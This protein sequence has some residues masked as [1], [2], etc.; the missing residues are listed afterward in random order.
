[1]HALLPLRKGIY[2]APAFGGLIILQGLTW[3]PPGLRGLTGQ[4]K[5]RVQSCWNGGIQGHVMVKDALVLNSGDP[6]PGHE[7]GPE[8]VL[9]VI[10]PSAPLPFTSHSA[11]PDQGLRS[12]N[13]FRLSLL[14]FLLCSQ[15]QLCSSSSACTSESPMWC[16]CIS[17]LQPTWF[18]SLDYKFREDVG[19]ALWPLQHPA[20]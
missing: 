14:C 3:K 15:I 7:K 10:P 16:V 20:Q 4:W 12:L 11:A 5:V 18:S 2:W 1:M 19:C 13:Q 17:C 6:E 8:M 9:S